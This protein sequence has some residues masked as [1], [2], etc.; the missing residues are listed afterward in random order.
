MYLLKP[1]VS[2]NLEFFKYQKIQKT[3]K[4]ILDSKPSK[5]KAVFHGPAH[6]SAAKHACSYCMRL[7]RK[8]EKESY[9]L[10]NVLSLND[11]SSNLSETY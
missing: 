7:A 8:E 4:T 2:W 9:I 5:T 11:F 10:G 1:S 6:T 3:H